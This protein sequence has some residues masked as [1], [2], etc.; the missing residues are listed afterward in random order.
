MFADSRA[1]ASKNLKLFISGGGGAK[2]S[3][4]LDREFVRSLKTDSILYIPIGLVR[5]LSGYDE[6]YEWICRTLGA[7]GKPLDISMWVDLH[8][9]NYLDL[10]KF[11]AVYI[12]GANNSYRLMSL[13]ESSGFAL[14]LRKFFAEGG[15]AYGGSTGAI[16]MGKY[17][18]VFGEEPVDSYNSPF[19]LGFAGEHSVFCHYTKQREDKIIAFMREYRGP[20]LAIPEGGGV[21]VDSFGKATVIGNEGIFTFDKRQNRAMINAGDSFTI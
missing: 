7:F 12:G 13:F 17:I 6:C 14:G 16:L 3:V 15:A 18:S 11:S 1:L 21:A 10:R 20:V 5:D 4:A 2:E 9:K 8:A 19:G